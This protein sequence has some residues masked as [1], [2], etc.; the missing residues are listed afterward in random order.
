MKK[1]ARCFAP[2]RKRGTKTGRKGRERG[3]GEEKGKK[4]GRKRERVNA[5]ARDTA[6]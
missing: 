1:A 5:N 2:C 4:G 3:I 6:E